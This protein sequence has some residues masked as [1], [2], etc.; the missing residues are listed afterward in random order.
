MEAFAS[1]G[2]TP[3]YAFVEKRRGFR[4]VKTGCMYPNGEFIK[5]GKSVIGT[6]GDQK[7]RNIEFEMQGCQRGET[8][9]ARQSQVRDIL[10]FLHLRE[11]TLEGG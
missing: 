6:V 11:Q 1:R 2:V 5:Q 3:G 7:K 10:V 9:R 8:R 4:K